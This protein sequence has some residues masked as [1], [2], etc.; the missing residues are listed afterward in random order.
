VSSPARGKCARAVVRPRKAQS[1]WLMLALLA[2]LTAGWGTAGALMPLLHRRR[3]IEAHSSSAISCFAL[4][5]GTIGYAL[6]LVYG[7]ALR[8]VPLIVVDATGLAAQFATVTVALRL[9][10]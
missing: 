3:M 2:I 4:C 6:W 7:I 10:T 5:W 8:D 1:R 9:R